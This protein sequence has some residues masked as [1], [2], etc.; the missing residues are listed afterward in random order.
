MAVADMI[1]KPLVIV[2]AVVVGGN[3]VFFHS[4]VDRNCCNSVG[5]KAVVVVV[6]AVDSVSSAA[7][8]KHS[9]SSYSS[10]LAAAVAAAVAAVVDCNYNF[11]CNCIAEIA[12]VVVVVWLVELDSHSIDSFDLAYRYKRFVGNYLEYSADMK[13]VVVAFHS[14]SHHHLTIDSTFDC[15]NRNLRQGLVRLNSDWN[16]RMMRW[17]WRRKASTVASVAAAVDNRIDPA[18]EPAYY[19][20][21]PSVV[22]VVVA[23][24]VDS[25]LAVM[26]FDSFDSSASSIV[27]NPRNVRLCTGDVNKPIVVK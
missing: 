26:T 4:V 11:H 10:N 22:V 21:T 6:V 19:P 23:T 24:V 15:S 13:P 17:W 18:F 27:S 16:C 20:D 25:W 7:E 8:D 5:K 12:L 2:V 14:D 9:D 3:S 1:H